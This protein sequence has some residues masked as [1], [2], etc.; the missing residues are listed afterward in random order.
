MDLVSPVLAASIS[1]FSSS[2]FRVS[3]TFARLLPLVF[4]VYADPFDTQLAHSMEVLQ[5]SEAFKFV[6]GKLQFHCVKGIVRQRSVI[7]LAKWKKRREKPADFSELDEAQV[8]QTEDRGPLIEPSWTVTT[9]HPD[10]YVK[11]PDLFEYAGPVE[12]LIRRDVEACEL[13]RKHPHPNIA[14]YHGC[15]ETRGRVSGLCFER[16]TSTLAEKVNPEHLNKLHFVSNGRPLVDQASMRQALAGIRE[17]IR[18][19]HSLGLVH[20]DITPANIMLKEDDTWVIID[21]DSCRTVGEALRSESGGTKRTYGWH[22]P[23]VATAVE[24]NDLDALAELET[25]LFG[26][27]TGFLFR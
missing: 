22:D 10:F 8:L 2:L 11:T 18:H 4:L 26:D 9:R 13:L 16:Y 25:W 1:P 12:Y 24:K 5:F 6:D 14:A 3:R 23:E 7:Y 15:L 17:G 21:F 20:N 19:L 27:S